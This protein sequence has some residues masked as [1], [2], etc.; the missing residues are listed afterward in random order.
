MIRSAMRNNFPGKHIVPKGTNSTLLYNIDISYYS[1]VVIRD[2][3]TVN[4]LRSAAI[5]IG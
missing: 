2:T 5:I 1:G 4:N 3:K